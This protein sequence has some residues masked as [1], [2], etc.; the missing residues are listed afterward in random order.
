MGQINRNGVVLVG[1]PG[2]TNLVGV[3]SSLQPLGL[4]G[5]IKISYFGVIDLYHSDI[6][7]NTSATPTWLRT[8]G[9]GNN[10]MNIGY[11][12]GGALGWLLSILLETTAIS[13]VISLTLMY[14]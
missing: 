9:F 1:L 10:S 11:D 13:G 3:T 14:S 8:V 12:N 4:Q 6:L 2:G 5:K 7:V